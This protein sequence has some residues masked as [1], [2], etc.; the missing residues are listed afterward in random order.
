[1]LKCR[2]FAAQDVLVPWHLA[3][4]HNRK[5]DRLP[6]DDTHT[7]GAVAE[8]DLEPDRPVAQ[9]AATAEKASSAAPTP[10]AP[11]HG[12]RVDAVAGSGG[13]GGGGG[14]VVYQ[15]YCHVYAEGELEEL[16]ERVDGLRL[17]ESYYDRS[18]WCIVAEREG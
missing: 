3:D 14:S 16:V 10:T 2:S 9:A 18:N 13:G 5:P 1:M 17:V 6:Q 15:R 4:H 7:D 12:V 11:R 8:D